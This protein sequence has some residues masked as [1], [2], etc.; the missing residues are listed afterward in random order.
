VEKVQA[1]K[2]KK[3]RQEKRTMR[4]EKKPG[5]GSGSEQNREQNKKDEKKK[6]LDKK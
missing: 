4:E 5:V 6:S 1:E 3:I 2:R